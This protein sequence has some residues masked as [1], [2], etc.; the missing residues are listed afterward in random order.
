MLVE[1]QKKMRAATHIPVGYASLAKRCDRA[2]PFVVA[3][4]DDIAFL[5]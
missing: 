2:F 5:F 3:L 4:I 1:P